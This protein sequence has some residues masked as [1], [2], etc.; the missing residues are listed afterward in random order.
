MAFDTSIDL[1]LPS[2]SSN[3]DDEQ[4]DELISTWNSIINLALAVDDRVAVVFVVFSETAAYGQLINLYNNGGVLNARLSNLSTSAKPVRG[5]CSDRKGV[6][7]GR[8]GLVICSGRVSGLS[9]LTPGSLYYGSNT[10]G[11]ASVIA[12]TVSQPI[13]FALSTTTLCLQPTLI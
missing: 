5:F 2:V 1:K 7:A 11:S 6:V 13:G 10:P 12:G 8:T 4:R 9:G 3:T